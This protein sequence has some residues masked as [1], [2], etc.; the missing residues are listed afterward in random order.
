MGFLITI[1]FGSLLWMGWPST[2]FCEYWPWLIWLWNCWRKASPKLPVLLDE[3]SRHACSCRPKRRQSVRGSQRRLVLLEVVN[4]GP[5][6]RY[7]WKVWLYLKMGVPPKFLCIK[8]VYDS[9]W[10]FSQ[11]NPRFL[12]N[13]TI[14]IAS[15]L[16]RSKF[17]QQFERFEVSITIWYHL[18]ICA[19]AMENHHF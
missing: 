11:L 10:P 13:A 15:T 14:W 16:P 3:T 12:V 2:I 7:L 1:I 8:N 6:N 4:G 17:N 9:L 18:V 5:K 19:I